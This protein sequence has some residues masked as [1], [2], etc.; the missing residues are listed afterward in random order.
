MAFKRRKNEKAS[1]FE[2]EAE[3]TVLG[4]RKK[5]KPDHVVALAVADAVEDK[6]VP[7]LEDPIRIALMQSCQGQLQ[8]EDNSEKSEEEEKGGNAM[9]LGDDGDGDRIMSESESDGK[10]APQKKQKN[11][12]RKPGSG[13]VGGGI[14]WTKME[15]VTSV[16]PTDRT[17][18]GPRSLQA[19]DAQVEKQKNMRLCLAPAESNKEHYAGLLSFNTT[20]L[21]DHFKSHHQKLFAW[22]EKARK[23]NEDM[24]AA[25]ANF[26]RVH[27]SVAPK[28][29]QQLTLSKFA[30]RVQEDGSLEVGAIKE[31][32][33]ALKI[34]GTDSSFVSADD[35]IVKVCDAKL[36]VRL[37]GAEATRNRVRLIAQVVRQMRR[38]ELESAQFF[39]TT[40]DFATV[41]G[42]SVLMI[43]YHIIPRNFSQ[44]RAFGLDAIVFPGAHYA[45]HIAIAA[46]HRIDSHTNDDCVHVQ[47]T[48]DGAADVQKAGFILAG[49][50]ALLEAEEITI[51]ELVKEIGG[52]D[53]GRCF[54]HAEH[55]IIS[56]ALGV[57]GQL[58]AAKAVS[59]DL[60]FIHQM[61]VY[62]STYAKEAAVLE[63]L[64]REKGI[65]WPL[66]VLGIE[67]ETRWNDRQLALE[68]FLALRPCIEQWY[69]LPECPFRVDVETYSDAL[70]EPFWKRVAGAQNVL[71]AFARWSS[72]LQTE[73]QITG[74]WLPRCVSELR[75]ACVRVEG[76]VGVVG[77]TEATAQLKSVLLDGIEEYLVPHLKRVSAPLKASVLD[78]NEAN[79]AGYGIDA[80]LINQVWEAVVEEVQ[81]Y[82]PN[83]SGLAGILVKNL[84]SRLEE[85][86]RNVQAG[87]ARH[88]VLEFWRSIKEESLDKSLLGP[89]FSETAR[90]ILTIQLSSASTERRVK[91]L[92]RILTEERNRLGE[93]TAEDIYVV[94]D[95]LME[96]EFTFQKFDELIEAVK[97]YI[98]EN[99]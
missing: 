99:K 94:R 44:I 90:A 31:I 19:L 93:V 11:P 6:S 30:G 51:P 57:Q 58:G 96:G 71:S 86:S 34:V 74:S 38:R 12:G 10:E 50:I 55:L 7:V 1:R 24:S 91:A 45:S 13:T 84:R 56:A 54:A 25:L 60:R 92:K 70:T 62:F 26:L 81:N 89:V 49:N 85:C 68:R 3:G 48:P 9:E 29:M 77:D 35:S 5:K 20:N 72:L 78:P 32:A 67:C 28:T 83:H 73:G 18:L 42:R 15:G 52:G 69:L 33:H 98:K 64:Q 4:E 61:A 75:A 82:A 65:A 63:R 40:F 43:T 79:L 16:V 46:Q 27:R 2:R 36:G 80:E 23:E 53:A 97:A 37:P 87:G 95:W 41:E 21:L 22:M 8:E 17:Q 47:A 14:S 39:S 66:I 59:L 88:D 76:G